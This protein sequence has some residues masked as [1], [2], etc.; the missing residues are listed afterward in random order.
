MART[1]NEDCISCG[2]CEPDCPQTAITAG[3]SIYI[4]D[5][6]K[7]NECEGLPEAKCMSVCP[8]DCIELAK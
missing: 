7:C 1:I 2:L 3:D 8:V 6:A 4:I 5:P